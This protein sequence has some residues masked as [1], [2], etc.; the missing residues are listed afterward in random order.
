[1]ADTILGN[2]SP[3]ELMALLRM[4]QEQQ[5]TPPLANAQISGSQE[6]S[7]LD[8]FF[9]GKK[10]AE[11][12]L[13]ANRHSRRPYIVGDPT[14][15]SAMTNAIADPSGPNTVMAGLSMLP[16]VPTKALAPMA[17]TAGLGGLFQAVNND[18]KAADSAR[19]IFNRQYEARRPAP[20]DPG[21]EED[22]SARKR[23]ELEQSGWYRGLIEQKATKRAQER[24]NAELEKERKNYPKAKTDYTS[25]LEQWTKDR[26]AAFAADQ[27]D[28]YK[29]P[30]AERNPEV[31]QTLFTAG[32]AYP[33]AMGFKQMGKRIAEKSSLLNAAREGDETAV[34]ALKDYMSSG[35][36]FG[37]AVDTTKN[38]AKASV[39]PPVAN[40]SGDYM[41]KYFAPSDSEAHKA[42]ANRLDV[43]N[44]QGL[45]EQALKRAPDWL[46]G[47][48]MYGLGSGLR[49]MLPGMRKAPSNSEVRGLLSNPPSPPTT[50]PVAPNVMRTLLDNEVAKVGPTVKGTQG[51]LTKA[52]KE[53]IAKKSLIDRGL[54]P[55]D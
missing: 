47:A 55:P 36:K 9:G 37:R 22:F 12:R 21:S 41:D 50:P 23:T 28:V 3:Q 39:A 17:A 6:P 10:A 51:F 35:A 53:E 18:A 34:A 8:V 4:G 13:A 25:A 54:L 38:M 32:L 7:L 43:T 29:K 49:Y 45:K 5:P 16:M 48:E 33:A 31:A 42:A 27:A 2:L 14:P 24:L 1:M 26:E 11:D 40:L 30:F 19:D 52:Q 44:L 15:L 20:K 46:Y